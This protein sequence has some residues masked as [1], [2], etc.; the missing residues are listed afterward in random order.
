MMDGTWAAARSDRHPHPIAEAMRWHAA[1]G[2][3]IQ[4][5]GR[6]EARTGRRRTRLTCWLCATRR[7]PSGGAADECADLAP[8]PV[9]RMLAA[10]RVLAEPSD[11]ARCYPGSGQPAR[12]LKSIQPGGG[13]GHSLIDKY[14]SRDV[15]HL[16]LE[17]VRYQIADRTAPALRRGYGAVRT[18]DWLE[19][20]LG[21]LSALR[22]SHRIG[23]ALKFQRK[24]RSHRQPAA[25]G[26]DNAFSQMYG[27]P[28]ATHGKCKQRCTIDSKYIL[29]Y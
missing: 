20:R 14:L 25:H 21:L 3:L 26:S 28:I 15:P 5:I 18:E 9:D 12:R 23:A 1:E 16:G 19:A 7:F 10:G 6:S 22:W 24:S 2:E 8:S 29:G 13:A 4:I 27:P 17:R 11:A